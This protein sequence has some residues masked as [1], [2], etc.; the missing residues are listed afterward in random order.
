MKTE[1]LSTIPVLPTADIE[2]DKAWYQEKM[3]MDVLFSDSMY[4]VLFR[5]NLCL[6]LQW[7]ADTPDDPLLG[8][9]VVRI[10]VKNIQPIFEEFIQRGTVTR[11][12]FRSNTPWSTNEFGFYDLN[13]NAVFIM[14][15]SASKISP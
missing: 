1:F 10:Y 9:S 3:G 15:D 13:N 6:H 2:R 5:E 8:G 14:E 7:H 11:E 12:K 4:A